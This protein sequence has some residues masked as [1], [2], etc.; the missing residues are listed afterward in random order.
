MI[1][2]REL[3]VRDLALIEE[4]RLEFGPGLN[5]LT[6]ETGAGK[7]VLVEALDLLLGGRGD[8]GLIRSGAERL[9]LEAA[10]ELAGNARLRALAEQE[11][12]EIEGDEIILRRVIAGDGRGRCYA[13]GR[14]CTVGALARIGEYIV[15]I[16]GQHEHQRLMKP[17]SHLEYLDDYGSPEHAGLLSEYGELYSKWR[18][19]R[20][21]AQGAYMDEAERLREIDLLGFQ[22]REIEA[23]R[24]LQGEME[25][26][27]RQR[28]R[29]QNREELFTAARDAYIALASDQEMG[30]A[31]G[32]VGTAESLLERASSLDE[33]LSEWLEKLRG[34]QEVLTDLSHE[35]RGYHESLDFEP[36]RL[37]EV[38][39]RLRALGD[40]ARKYGKDTGEVLR[41]LE[42]SRER[43]EEL[44]NLSLVREGLE[45]ELHDLEKE[46]R[47]TA[48]RLTDGRRALAGKLTRETNRE[49]EELNMAGVRFRVEMSQEEGFTER[50][51]DKV[52]FMISPGKELAYRVISRIASGGELSRIML[53]L[54]LCLAKA[55][56]VPTLVF[57]EVDAGIGGTTADVLAGKLKSI[58]R[59][60]QVFSITHLPSI[61]AV[62]DRHMSVTKR[63]TR[64]GM[65]TDVKVLEDESRLDELV[66]M[67]G[68]D[69]ATARDHALSMMEK[70][71]GRSPAGQRRR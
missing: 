53:A 67:L 15:D 42:V 29:M 30:G 31:I 41:H 58:S 6:G 11:G 12:L 45:R 8:S 33:E 48:A 70:K 22:V 39:G 38:E 69:E 20:D 52:A 43:L 57:D 18:E 68:G 16:H 36:D 7:T 27:L 35:L 59:Y 28:K 24:P 1:M 63:E 66:R 64:G 61:A 5:V 62:S 4:A 9:E 17:S 49:L 34:L 10:F 25:D 60:H 47:K 26:L 51:K 50:G 44:Q 56:E 54:K 21:R 14:M 23:V 40:L 13:N 46:L 71:P 37:E 55:D 65:V 3:H 2:L 19:A 32:L